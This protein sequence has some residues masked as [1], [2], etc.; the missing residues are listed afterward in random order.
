MAGA[1]AEFG[2]DALL[3]GGIEDEGERRFEPVGDFMFMR[4]ERQVGR[5]TPTTGVTAKPVTVR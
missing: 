1:A 3:V 2:A 4:C 5:D